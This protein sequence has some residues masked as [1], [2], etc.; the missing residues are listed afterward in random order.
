MFKSMLNVHLIILMSEF[1]LL[2]FEEHF[3]TEVSGEATF[4]RIQVSTS[5]EENTVVEQFAYQTSIN[6]RGHVFKGILYNQ[7]PSHPMVNPSDM[8]VHDGDQQISRINIPSNF[9]PVNTPRP[10]AS[11]IPPSYSPST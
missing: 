4:K 10:S 7:G 5:V 6:V 8:N 9:Q 2:G 3:P 1:V 11:S